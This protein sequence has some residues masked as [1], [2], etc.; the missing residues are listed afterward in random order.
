[1]KVLMYARDILS[2]ILSC[3]KVIGGGGVPFGVHLSD[4]LE[5]CS[6]KSYS[7]AS[8]LIIHRNRVK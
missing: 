8:G 6:R 5:L 3:K 7:R 2:K 4:L 1:M